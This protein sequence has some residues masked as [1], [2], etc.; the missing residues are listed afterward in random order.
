MKNISHFAA[1]TDYLSQGRRKR[2]AVVC[3]EDEHTSSAVLR[4]V[5]EGFVKVVFVGTAEAQAENES[6]RSVAEHVDVITVASPDD[7]AHEAVALVRRGEADVLMKGLINTDNLLRAVL[8][9]EDG[10]L[11][12]G[13]LLTHIAVAEVPDYPKLLFFT[14][15]AVLPYPTQEQRE[16]QVKY[17]ATLC[18]RFGIDEPRISLIHCSEKVDGRH[19]PHTLGY[20][21]IISKAAD[22]VYGRCKVD[23]P[24]DVK[25]SLCVESMRTKGIE[26]SLEGQADALIFPDIEAANTFYKTITL[27]GHA[28]T[29]AILQG[30]SAPVVLTSRADSTDSKYYSLALACIAG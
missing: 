18:H 30:A 10:I 2:V 7:A 9:K 4:A 6:L 3:G 22:G 28:R 12:Q 26:S 5:K 1:L 13:H 29:A 14:D 8:N 23:G 24:L 17:M 25:T 20:I 21:S 16:Q 11:P 15:A 27:F 19:F